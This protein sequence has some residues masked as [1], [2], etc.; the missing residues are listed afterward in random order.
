[1]RFNHRFLTHQRGDSPSQD[2]FK[3][4]AD[5]S[6]KRSFLSQI[7]VLYASASASHRY[8]SCRGCSTSREWQPSGIFVTYVLQL[9]ACKWKSIKT[10]STRR[11]L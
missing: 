10:K 9:F 7:P 1:M 2:V 11:I 8:T 5:L 4:D 6:Q 3:F